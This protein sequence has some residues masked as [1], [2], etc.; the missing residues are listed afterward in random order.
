MNRVLLTTTAVAL[1]SAQAFAA[2]VT[3]NTAAIAEAANASGTGDLS[4]TIVTQPAV[5]GAPTAAV[6]VPAPNAVIVPSATTTATGTVLVPAPAIAPA[7]GATVIVPAGT[8]DVLVPAPVLAPAAGNAA[9]IVPSTTAVVAVPSGAALAA[10]IEDDDTSEFRDALA[11]TPLPASF[12]PAKG[13][14]IFAVVD[15]EFDSGDDPTFYVVNEPVT[16]TAMAGASDRVETVS[17]DDIRLNRTGNSYYVDDMRVNAVDHAPGG[18]IYTIG[19]STSANLG[20]PM[21]AGGV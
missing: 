19:G 2:T 5:V 11:N 13:Y 10:R 20:T 18:V 6:I 4:T 3:T 9:V 17:G 8:T 16:L 1:L 12:D 7:A 15:G 21:K 14:T